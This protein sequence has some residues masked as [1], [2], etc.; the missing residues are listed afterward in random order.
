MNLG[1]SCIVAL[2]NWWI[3]VTLQLNARA[4]HLSLFLPQ[5]KNPDTREQATAKF[6]EISEAYEVGA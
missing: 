3:I 4:H 2:H 6:K 5:D 1:H